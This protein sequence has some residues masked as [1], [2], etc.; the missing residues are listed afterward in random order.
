MPIA[1]A[2]VAS[3]LLHAAALVGPGW[4]LPGTHDTDPPPA[5]DAVLT[6]PPAPVAKAAPKPPP[7]RPQPLPGAPAVMATES[8][9][10]IAIA[11]PAPDVPPPV[12]TPPAAA[13]PPAPTIAP[14]APQPAHTA[15][16][17]RGRLRYVITRGEGGFVIGQ[18][19]HNWEHDGFRYTLK[20]L[21]ETTGLAALF[22]PAQVLQTSQG[23]VTAE[24][25]KPFAFRHERTSGIDAATFD[26]ARR[27]V[28][29]AGR[30]E[31]I[32]AGTQDMLSMYYQIVLLAP[33]SGVLEMPIATGR[34]LET[35]RLEVL[36]EET[37]AL[38]SGERRALRIRTRSGNDS[39]ELWLAI[40]ENAAAR[41][42][43]LKIRFID[44]KGEIF[45]QVADDVDST[46]S[47]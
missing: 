20:S 14:P 5:I 6:K 17:G 28:A 43:P 15:L 21:T 9:A 45:D 10:A 23:E 42:L 46:E 7:A 4:V 30:E 3:V 25:L 39:I 27:M 40:G 37:L 44:R 13:V 29:Y 34:K 35:F 26:W 11:Q 8:P 1:L 16:P 33:K 2:L 31:S 18:S 22:K 38:A 41:G 24:G 19:V 47:K 12:D 32:I 36:G